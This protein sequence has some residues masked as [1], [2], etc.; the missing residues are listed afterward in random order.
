MI[1]ELPLYLQ[2]GGKTPAERRI[3][4]LKRQQN[5]Y[6]RR[7]SR[8]GVSDNYTNKMQ[9]KYDSAQAEID[10]LSTKVG[11]QAYG[12]AVGEKREKA[13]QIASGIASGAATAM[14]A[15]TA[16]ATSQMNIAEDSSFH[17]TQQVGQ[18]LSAFGPYGALA[19][20][21]LTGAAAL[22]EGLGI[23]TS[24]LSKTQANAAGL[25]G[26]QRFINNIAGILAPGIGAAL[27]KTNTA[28]QK[29]EEAQSVSG[30]Y[31]DAISDI[32]TAST[33]GGKRYAVGAG[34]I[35]ALIAEANRK[36][37]ILTEVGRVNTLRKQSDYGQD[38]LTQNQRI[39][40]GNNYM[41]SAI[42]KHGMKLASVDEI[43]KIL[44]LRNEEMIQAFQNG[45]VIGID[46]NVIPEGKYHA[47]KNHLSEVS[48]EFEDLT[49]KGIPVITHAEGGEIEQIAEI[50][51]MELILRLEVTEKLEELFKDGSD[52]AMIE[53][54]KLVAYEIMENT[55]DNSG[56]VLKNE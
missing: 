42:G 36:N 1:K 38:L 40:A 6:T 47:H 29:T 13:G 45:G 25:S 28:T 30:A 2:P 49:K 17:G 43:R 23:G 12:N 27:A 39:Y 56:E 11:A 46:V 21:A 55:Q 18:A 44:E 8:T 35:N 5:R 41:Q 51:K 34:Q 4:Q 3:N 19:G 10:K 26:G 24:Q 9:N 33:M 14:N 48:E 15:A 54:G 7:G 53:A 22:T 32:D 20:A 37:S 16:L 50:E 31:A 52:E